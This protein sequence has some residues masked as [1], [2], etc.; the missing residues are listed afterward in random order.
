MANLQQRSPAWHVARRGKMTASNLGATLGLVSYTSRK[1]AYSRAM[2]TDKFEGNDATQWGNDN[3][4]NGIMA[5]QSKTGNLVMPSGLHVHTDYK[6]LAGSP[7]GFVGDRGMIEVKRPFYFKRD[8][9]GRIH[10]TVPAHYYCQMNALME[11]CD[12][13]WCDYVC[14]SPEGMAIYRVKRDPMCFEILLHFYAQFYAAMQ[15]QSDAP[16]AQ[17]REVKG[18]IES[19]LAEAIERSVDYG[20]YAHVDPLEAVPSSDPYDEMEEDPIHILTVAET[21]DYLSDEDETLAQRAK[22]KRLSD[23]P[24]DRGNFGDNG[25]NEHREDTGSQLV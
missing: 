11:I 7:D 18:H 1:V 4:I 12:R 19:T 3:E 8:G 20:F 15:A 22:R 24:G 17:S 6:W 10:K 21:R 25:S 2:G 9:S 16:P 23:L 13:D 5:Y 14:W